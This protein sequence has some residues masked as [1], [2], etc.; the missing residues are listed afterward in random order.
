M[1]RNFLRDSQSGDLLEDVFIVSQ[2]QLSTT[3]T[4]KQ[5]IKL[6]ISDRTAQVTARIWNA[7]R[8]TFDLLP[9]SGFVRVRARVENYQGNIQVIVDDFAPVAMGDFDIADLIPSTTRDV[10][11]MRQR[12]IELCGTVRNRA[13]KCLLDAYLRDSNLLDR[14]CRAPA[15]QSFH[16]AFLGGL[17]EHTLNAMDVADAICKFY[18]GLSRDLV[19]AGILLHDIAK[20]WELSYE[21]SFAYTDGGQ[22][23]GHIV[24]S[25]IWVEDKAREA[26]AETGVR[27]PQQ[28]ID[29]LQHIIISHHGQPEFGAVKL[30]ATPEA[31]AV[32]FIENLDARMM[33]SLSA[34]RGELPPG[35]DGNWSEYQKALGTRLYRPDVAPPDLDAAGKIIEP[36]PAESS[37]PKTIPTMKVAVSNPLFEQAMSQKKRP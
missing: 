2:K 15:A 13:L 33:M 32:H 14:L 9:E 16:H 10:P 28:L 34:T 22:L 36:A 7:N 20:T 23:V 19:L 35:A 4:N 24:K 8:Q 27:I 18:P 29:V 11:A 12:L 31:I 37:A 30:P 1:R 26:E 5:Y 25:A 3:S 6:F 21:C 17:L